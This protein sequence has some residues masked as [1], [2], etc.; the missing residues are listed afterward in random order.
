MIVEIR[1]MTP[2]WAADLAPLIAKSDPWLR[3]GISA[4]K[5]EA[6][7]S[8]EKPDRLQKS[9]VA[10]G[11]PIGAIV[12]SKNWLAGF[13]LQHLSLLKPYRGI[14]A[15]TAALKWLIDRAT[16]ENQRSI[17]LC[18]SE[19]NERAEKF[20]EHHGFK[21]VAVI[22]ELLVA[23]ENEILMRRRLDTPAAPPNR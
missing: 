14:G 2:L 13:Y 20:Y 23:G 18:V 12:V 6:L 22:D 21:R 16:R 11:S 15:G 17:W 9:I 1:P 4:D 5:I 19:F 3:L 8:G 7:L 10:G